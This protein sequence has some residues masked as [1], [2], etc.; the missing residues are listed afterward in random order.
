M[1]TSQPT[2]T[3]NPQS[4][5]PYEIRFADSGSGGLVMLLD[6]LGTLAPK[7][8]AWQNK[9]NLDFRLSHLGDYVNQDRWANA[10]RKTD[11]E[12]ARE[13]KRLTG[14]LLG[15]AGNLVV[16]D[17]K[18][19]AV[20]RGVPNQV[21]VACNTASEAYQSHYQSNSEK[22]AARQTDKIM[23]ILQPS[24]EA[25]YHS[26]KVTETEEGGKVLS[27]AFFATPYTVETG[28]YQ[29]MLEEFM[30]S[31]MAKLA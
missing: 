7:L 21:V 1:K 3:A 18:E 20:R 10:A 4:V 22:L 31:I 5:E 25:L 29:K 17:D 9:Y 14:A 13:I 24:A 26:G 16:A 8:A 28:V 19:D 6:A 30:P 12:H 2:Q 27:L 11:E 15:I 23:P